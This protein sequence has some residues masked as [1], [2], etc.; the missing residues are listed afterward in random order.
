MRPASAPRI[1]WVLAGL[2]L[3][4]AYLVVEFRLDRGKAV[5][6]RTERDTS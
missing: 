1:R 5:A 3:A 4:L 2:A 6:G